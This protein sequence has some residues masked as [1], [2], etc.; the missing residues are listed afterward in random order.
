ML[1]TLTYLNA[2]TVV[3]DLE[4]FEASILDQNFDRGRASVNGIL[5]E[6]LECIHWSNN[7]LTGGNFVD[8][9]FC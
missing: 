3:R 4:E 7:D 2:V 8:D 9:I 6:L 5:Q 1:A